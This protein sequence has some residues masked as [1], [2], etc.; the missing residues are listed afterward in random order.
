MIE[1]ATLF[2]EQV[3]ALL[4]PATLV[5]LRVGAAVAI[6]PGF[7]EQAIPA[8]IRLAAALAF[9]AVILPAVAGR[10]RGDDILLPAAAEVS[11]GLLIG[12][13]LRLLILGLQTAAAISAQSASLSQ[14]F[15]SA[16]SEPQPALGILFTLAAT[17]L[18]LQAGLHVKLAA[19]LILS[20]D[21]LPAGRMVA[22]ADVMAWG[23]GNVARAT[24]LAFS[25]AL[26]FVM[27]ALLWNVALGAVNRAMPQLMV[28]FIG[29]PALSIGALA[30]A[31]VITPVIL[32]IWLRA[33]DAQL[34]TPFG[35]G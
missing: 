2:V 14:F 31:A 11:A 30:L 16:G 19:Y 10:Y 12:L 35:T 25:L 4:R 9:T 24:A 33:L 3:Q 20:Y 15:A 32:F 23:V 7:G 22:G 8:R 28:T 27:A 29:A 6:L 18:A 26:P 21:V 13:S 1:L 5:F 34:V 17:A